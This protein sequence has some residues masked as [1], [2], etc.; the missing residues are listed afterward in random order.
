MT[1]FKQIFLASG[2]VAVLATGGLAM[3][4]LSSAEAAETKMP[5]DMKM[6][7]EM[8]MPKT[9]ADH[10]A[11]AAKY[12]QEAVSLETKAEHH[13]KKGGELSGARRCRRQA[14]GELP[15]NS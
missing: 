7:G 5:A 12:D 15:V 2:L 11:E 9:A 4:S 8:S 1:Q 3:T 6:S 14:R 10:N 13:A